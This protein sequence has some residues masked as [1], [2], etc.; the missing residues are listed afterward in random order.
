MTLE[1][2]RRGRRVL[3]AAVA[4]SAIALVTAQTRGPA[5]GGRALGWAAALCFVVFLAL[6]LLIWQREHRAAE[7]AALARERQ[8]LELFKRQLDAAKQKL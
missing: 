4:L 1:G 3:S 7:R 5:S 6:W 2:L 8:Q